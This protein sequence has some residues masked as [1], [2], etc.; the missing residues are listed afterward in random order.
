MTGRIIEST[1]CQ[2]MGKGRGPWVYLE[3]HRGVEGEIVEMVNDLV[4]ATG[5]RMQSCF[6][7]TVVL[8][9]AAIL[10]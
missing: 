1:H 10:L 4:P 9:A 8:S 5:T 3:E 7:E 2:S 6:L